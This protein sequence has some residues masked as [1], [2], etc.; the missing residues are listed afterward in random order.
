M[1]YRFFLYG[2]AGWCIEIFWTGLG[3]ALKGSID[4]KGFTY[5]WMLPIYGMG[6]FMEP[7]HDKIR[8]Y[9]LLVRGGVWVL[10]IFTIEY[11]S[12]WLLSVT[13]GACPWDYTGN[14]PYSVNGYIRLDYALPWFGVGIIFEH[15]HDYLDNLIGHVSMG[16]R[17]SIK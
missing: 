3:T 17:R 6:V 5:I 10:I 16:I 13:T 7:I 2:F 4:M 14:T 8:R 11:L 1:I 12:G 15:I 9:P